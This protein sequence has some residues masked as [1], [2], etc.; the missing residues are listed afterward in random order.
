MA[1]NW[2]GPGFIYLIRAPNNLYKIGM[3]INIHKRFGELKTLSPVPLQ[4]IHV[5]KTPLRYSAERRM[6]KRFKKHRHHGEWF[7]LTEKHVEWLKSID[8]ENFEAKMEHWPFIDGLQFL[9]KQRS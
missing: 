9:S 7:S 3:A 2:Q 1:K 8:E 4:L 5:I 6:H